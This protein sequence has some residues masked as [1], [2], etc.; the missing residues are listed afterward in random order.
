MIMAT[1]QII[2]RE[3][4]YWLGY[5]GLL[6]IVAG[7]GLLAI[8]VDS[9]VVT[10]G[11]QTYAA[12]I[13]TFVGAVHWGRSLENLEIETMIPSVAPSLLAWCTLFMTPLIAL[14]LLVLGFFSQYIFDARQSQ[15]KHWYKN[16]R[17]QLTLIIC[18]L[19]SLSWLLI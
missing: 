5:L 15:L 3:R 18:A 9:P 11:I 1:Q 4:A 7:A 8:Q 6:P 16:L 13:L 12:V 10:T 2:L 19:L 14:P 17:L